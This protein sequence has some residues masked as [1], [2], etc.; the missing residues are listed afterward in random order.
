MPSQRKEKPHPD[1]VHLQV[2]VPRRVK[3]ALDVKAAETGRT[4]RTIVLDALRK[5]GFDVTDEEVAG[6]RRGRE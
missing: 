4:K 3:H 2:T 6:R 1:E 5:A